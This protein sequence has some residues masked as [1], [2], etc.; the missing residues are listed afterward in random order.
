MSVDNCF[1]LMQNSFPESETMMLLLTSNISLLHH[2]TFYGQN[3]VIYMV[4]NK[5]WKSNVGNVHSWFVVTTD[6]ITYGIIV[7]VFNFEFCSLS[8]LNIQW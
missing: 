1:Y 3:Q 7:L 6:K 5:Q 4:Y 8:S 2:I